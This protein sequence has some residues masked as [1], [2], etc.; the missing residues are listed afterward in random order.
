M[1]FESYEIEGIVLE[2][3][4]EPLSLAELSRACAAHAE[5]IMALINEG[6]LEPS[7]VRRETWRFHASSLRRVR[8]VQRLQRD[9]GIN[10]AGA[11]LALDLL[12]EIA[13]LRARQATQGPPKPR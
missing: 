7:G 1:E 8:T 13:D 11:A 6:I 4:A 12:D 5:W 2:D 10:L 3:E 9:L